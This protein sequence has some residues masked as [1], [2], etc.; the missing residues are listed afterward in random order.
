MG[1]YQV[2]DLIILYLISTYQSADL[3]INDQR[4]II[5]LGIL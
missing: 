5:F 4:I 2:T 3:I 1:G